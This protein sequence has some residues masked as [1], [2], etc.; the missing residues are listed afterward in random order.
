MRKSALGVVVLA[1]AL[2]G[3]QRTSAMAALGDLMRAYRNP[4]PDAGDSFGHCVA[5]L[6]NEVLVG[7]PYDDTY[8]D[9][10]GIVYLL[11]ASGNV[12]KTFH[13]PAPFANERFGSHFVAVGE[14]VLIFGN[15]PEYADNDIGYLFEVE[16]GKV[17]HTFRNPT[18]A[19]GDYFG[20]GVA[21]EDDKIVISARFDDAYGTNAGAVHLFSASSGKLERTF[22]HSGQRP[23]DEFGV[24]IALVGGNVLVGAHRD[25]SGATDSGAAYLFDP[26]GN[27][28]R[29]FL[30]PTRA[31][32]EGFGVRV[33][34]MD[35]KVLIVGKGYDTSADGHGAAYV[36]A[37][38]TGNVL[39]TLPNPALDGDA[40]FGQSLVAVGDDVLVGAYLD[41]TVAFDSGA[42]YLFDGTTGEVLYTF[43]DPTPD[44]REWFGM[45][46]AAMDN[47]ILIGGV[48]DKAGADKVGSAYLFQG[49]PEPSVLTSLMSMFI[50]VLSFLHTYFPG[51]HRSHSRKI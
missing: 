37:S 14:N 26:L 28:V 34:S 15:D 29:T 2:T 42:A 46:V 35:N 32:N 4:T 30:H 11:D 18:P 27:V 19:A 17:L 31:P 47:N 39:T 41:D 51:G 48:W 33:R 40:G 16:T 10:A 3:V 49:V 20:W 7:A 13:G 5:A 8:G 1:L 9:D 21:A 45:S 12:S 23:N 38:D 50:V 24:S 22:H 25:D 6:G 44:T 43:H 36:C